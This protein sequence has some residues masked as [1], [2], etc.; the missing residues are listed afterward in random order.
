MRLARAIVFVMLAGVGGALADGQPGAVNDDWSPI[1]YPL[2]RLPLIFSH[3]KH[4][5]RAP[6][7]R[8]AACHPGYSPDRPVERVYLTPTPLKF[9]HAAHAKQACTSCHGD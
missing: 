5:A 1:M 8:C 7:A 4:L 2:Q 6:P 3:G 9:A